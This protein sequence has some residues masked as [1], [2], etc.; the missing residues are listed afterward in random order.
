M[1]KNDEIEKCAALTRNY[2][3]SR[4]RIQNRHK[5]SMVELTYCLV[6]AISEKLMTY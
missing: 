2:K 3:N 5:E 6:F 1:N 4:N